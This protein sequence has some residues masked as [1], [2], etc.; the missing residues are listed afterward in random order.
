MEGSRVTG[1]RSVD[2]ATVTLPDQAVQL[3]GED[4]AL[5]LLPEKQVLAYFLNAEDALHVTSPAVGL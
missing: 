3:V 4:D 2:S 1:S 5:D